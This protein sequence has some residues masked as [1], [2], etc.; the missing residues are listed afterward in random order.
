MKIP[1]KIKQILKLKRKKNKQK[2]KTTTTK[3]NNKKEKKK[4]F[5]NEQR[6]SLLSCLRARQLLV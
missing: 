6:T 3:N 2:R 1:K 5:R 4:P